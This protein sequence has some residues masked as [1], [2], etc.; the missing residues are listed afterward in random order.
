VGELGNLLEHVAILITSLTGLVVAMRANR[1]STQ[2]E[3]GTK[4]LSRKLDEE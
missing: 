4:A 1:R 3:N 2:A